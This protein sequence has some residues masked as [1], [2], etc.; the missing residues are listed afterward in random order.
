VPAAFA[1]LAGCVVRSRLGESPI[2][3]MR[4]AADSQT[5]E[6]TADALPAR[7]IDGVLMCR[8]LRGIGQIPSD[9]T[10]S[11]ARRSPG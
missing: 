1:R 5:F 6:L 10:N 3:R 2:L 9:L 7:L 8:G 4:R 11:S